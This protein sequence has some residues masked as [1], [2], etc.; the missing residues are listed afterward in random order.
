M[1]EKFDFDEEEMHP[2][3]KPDDQVNYDFNPG[4]CNSKLFLWLHETPGDASSIES[5]TEE[6]RA[7]F[8]I[9]CYSGYENK[10]RHNLNSALKPW[11]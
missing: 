8:V 2:L 11:R 3:D 6:E 7:W 9:H 1:D 5:G 4:R 10:V